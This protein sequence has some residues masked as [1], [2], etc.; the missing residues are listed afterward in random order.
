MGH[1]LINRRAAIIG[2]VISTAALAV[3]VSAAVRPMSLQQLAE[4]FRDDAMAIDPTIIKCWVYTDELRDGP[5]E[6]RVMGVMIE[7]APR[8]P[9][10]TPTADEWWDE[11]SKLTDQQKVTYADMLRQSNPAFNE[12][13]DR[14]EAY[15]G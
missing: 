10:S 9:R 3:P 1:S 6:D 13:A 7:R 2:A 4:K 14:I 11:F 5:R 8:P 15:Y 12:L